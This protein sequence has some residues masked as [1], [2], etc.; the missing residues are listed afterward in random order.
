METPY[1]TMIIL[2]LVLI[3][4]TTFSVLF[5]NETEIDN[6]G[7]AVPNNQSYDGLGII[8]NLSIFDFI[9]GVLEIQTGLP[10]IDNFFKAFIG[11]VIAILIVWYIRAA[12]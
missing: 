11:I 10:I 7:Y 6:V 9:K 3:G 5:N 8:P 1:K 2:A 12:N 4:F